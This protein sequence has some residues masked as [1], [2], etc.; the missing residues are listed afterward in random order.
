MAD[1]RTRAASLLP[2]LTAVVE[3]ESWSCHVFL[4]ELWQLALDGHREDDRDLLTRV[5]GFAHWCF[6]QEQFLANA[7][8]VSF[9]EHVFDE[10]EL[11]DAVA[12]WLPTEVV[13]KVR[14]LWEWRWPQERLSEVDRL[15]SGSGTP[16]ERAV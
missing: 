6:R 16:G 7:A 5:Y 2:E 9:Y 11:R 10:W 8:V 3:R 4:T 13:D 1:W 12:P 14:P 15:L